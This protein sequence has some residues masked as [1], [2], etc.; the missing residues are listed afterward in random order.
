MTLDGQPFDPSL[1]VSDADRDRVT[2]QLREAFAEGRLT[3]EEFHERAGQALAARTGADLIALTADLPAPTPPAVSGAASVAQSA[4]QPVRSGELR[5]IWTAWASMAILLT[6][7]WVLTA[8]TSSSVPV[9]WPAWPL[10]IT[11]ALGLV[12]TINIRNADNGP[13]PYPGPDPG[14]YGPNDLRRREAR[15]DIRRGRRSR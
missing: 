1:R 11:G 13:G 10:G 3:A 5:R 4:L 14:R 7:V 9:F 12:R 2:G 8:V 15:R 6:A